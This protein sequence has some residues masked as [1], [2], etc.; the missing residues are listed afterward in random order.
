MKKTTVLNPQFGQCAQFVEELDQFFYHEGKTIYKERNEIKVFPFSEEL[1]LNVK[2]YAVPSPFFN[3]YVYATIRKP[4]AERA[5]YYALKLQELEVPT[6][7]PIAYVVHRTCVQVGHSYLVTEQVPHRRNMYEFGHSYLEGRGE[8]VR[9]LA[10]FTAE[11]HRK[12]VYHKDYSPGNI[13]F[14]DDGKGSYTFCLVDINRMEFGEP[15]S[16]KK[17]C[18]NFARLWG[19][20]D[21]IRVLSEEYAKARN[22]DFETVHG[23]IQKY[24][25]QFWKTRPEIPF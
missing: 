9:A 12:G 19:R 2:R 1:T 5:Y 18:K 3:K 24:H 11:I 22:A 20:E 8:V 4:K 15:I 13:L 21:F 6:P 14:D 16:L 25:R 17:G 7:T 23:W 10:R